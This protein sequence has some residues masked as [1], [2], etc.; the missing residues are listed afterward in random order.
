LIQKITLKKKNMRRN[1]PGL[2]GTMARTAVIT[3]TAGAVQNKQQQKF[4]AQ[5]AANTPDAPAAA[6]VAD[7]VDNQMAQIEQLGALLEK[8]LLT[9][10]EFDAKKKSILGL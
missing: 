5:N 1:R 6:P 8:G 7:S 3:G 2:I 9:Q 4:A 10:E